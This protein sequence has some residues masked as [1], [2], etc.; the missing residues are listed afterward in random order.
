MFVVLSVFRGAEN[1]DD[2]GSWEWVLNRRPWGQIIT[3]R[4][5]GIAVVLCGAELVCEPLFI[6]C[7]GCPQIYI[8]VRRNVDFLMARSMQ[9]KP[10]LASRTA[11][12]HT[13][14]AQYAAKP[15]SCSSEPSAA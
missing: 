2:V 14:L 3:D 15:L 4:S 11:V 6:A 5:C 8:G 13:W 1:T 10:T 7:C 12:L 9:V